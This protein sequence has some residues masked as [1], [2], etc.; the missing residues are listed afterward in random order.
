MSRSFPS[1]IEP[2]V[3]TGE[4]AGLASDLVETLRTR[5][6]SVLPNFGLPAQTLV[7]I[8]TELF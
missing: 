4:E 3:P 7:T 5:Q 8:L 2:P 6:K 1:A